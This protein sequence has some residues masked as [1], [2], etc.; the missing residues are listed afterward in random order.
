MVA[1][2][3]EVGEALLRALRA[4][5]DRTVAQGGENTVWRWNEAA[6]AWRLIRIGDCA[7]EPGDQEPFRAQA[8]SGAPEARLSSPEQSGIRHRLNLRA[9]WSQEEARRFAAAG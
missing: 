4:Q 9:R 1:D 6:L 7:A 3:D 5:R 2:P 8:P